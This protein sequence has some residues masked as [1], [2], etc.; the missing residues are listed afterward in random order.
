MR[1]EEMI[2][3]LIENQAYN[4][5]LNHNAIN[6]ETSEWDL[7]DLVNV[8]IWKKQKDG[9]IFCLGKSLSQK[10]FIFIPNLYTPKNGQLHKNT[11]Y[12]LSYVEK[13]TLKKI[14]ANETINCL[15][16]EIC[17]INGE[18]EHGEVFEYS[19]DVYCFLMLSPLFFEKSCFNRDTDSQSVKFIKQ[20]ILDKTKNYKAIRFIPKNKNSQIPRLFE[21]ILTELLTQEIGYN[22]LILGLVE[23]LVNLIFLDY[24]MIM[25]KKER[26][27]YTKK[28]F[29]DVVKYINDNYNTVTEKDLAELFYYT[30]E[31]LNRVIKKYSQLS[32]SKYLQ[33]VRM[34]KAKQFLLTTSLSVEEI[35]KRVGYTNLNF[36][37][38]TF[39]LNFG[40]TP[41]SLR[42]KS[43]SE[44]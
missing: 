13:G 42:S 11:F 30:P 44:T 40:C 14:V 39:K 27:T 37:Y 21:S 1:I 17:I 29:N 20:I 22:S 43:T 15:Q 34:G 9:Q 12:E 26:I 3:V 24:Q 6:S 7:K 28:L 23:R 25:T 38:K 10:D 18:C 19:D 33:K 16:N 32:Y 31:Y 4:K 36:F 8:V 5:N 2:D 35:A 41:N